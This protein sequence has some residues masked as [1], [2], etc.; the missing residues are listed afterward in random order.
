MQ[1]NAALLQSSKFIFELP[2]I[3]SFTIRMCCVKK[4]RGTDAPVHK[5][6]IQ[7]F[8]DATRTVREE[9]KKKQVLCI[10]RAKPSLPV[11]SV[12]AV[13]AAA[14]RRLGLGLGPGPGSVRLAGRRRARGAG[15]RSGLGAGRLLVGAVVRTAVR[16]RLVVVVVVALLAVAGTVTPGV[17]QAPVGRRSL[18]VRRGRVHRRRVGGRR[19]RR[20]CA[21]RETGVQSVPDGRWRNW[22]HTHLGQRCG[23]RAQRIRLDAGVRVIA[24]A[25]VRGR[26]RLRRR[27]WRRNGR[28]RHQFGGTVGGHRQRR[29]GRRVRQQWLLLL[30]LLLAEGGARQLALSAA[31]RGRLGL[32]VLERTVRLHA[33]VG[34]PALPVALLLRAPVRLER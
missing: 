4:N 12:A 31:V 21:L 1:Q 6:K 2:K 3:Q 11:E 25:A 33:A 14:A 23:R 15:L 16:L 19:R 8:E 28:Q 26:V 18:I 22:A 24:A 5:L 13:L 29:C 30:L 10:K 32:R 27:R 9:G 34:R 7:I 20:L 17:V